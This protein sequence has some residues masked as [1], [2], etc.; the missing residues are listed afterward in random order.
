[1]IDIDHLA[2]QRDHQKSEGQYDDDEHQ[3]GHDD[4]REDFLFF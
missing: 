3:Q 4:G 1:M 2:G